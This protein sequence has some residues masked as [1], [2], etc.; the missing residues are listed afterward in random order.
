MHKYLFEL[1]HQPHI[2]IA[3]IQAVFSHKKIKHKIISAQGGSASGGKNTFFV[4]ENTKELNFEDLINTLGGTIKIAEKIKEDN[5]TDFL[6]KTPEEFKIQFSLSGPNSKKI[7]MAIKKQLK[8][9]GRSV[10]YIEPKNTATIL[11]NKLIKK[12]GDLTIFEDEIYLTKAIQPFEEFGARDY[13]RPGTDSFSG[14]LPPKLARIMINLGLD[15]VQTSHGAPLSDV[16]LLDPFCGSGTVLTEALDL[17]FKNIIGSDISEKAI[18]DTDENIKW[19]EKTYNTKP[20]TL[21]LTTSDATKL[22]KELDEDS[23]DLIV[24]EPYMGKPLR[25]NERKDTLKKQTGELAELY[26][27]SFREFYQ[28]LKEGGTVIFIIPKFKD[29]NDWVEIDCI[30]DIKCEGFELIPLSEE[31]DSLTYHRS[32]QHV[33][34]VIWKFRKV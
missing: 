5:I 25:G 21:K 17:G 33:A 2:S 14:M 12:Q 4:V 11:H 7:A 32:K 6:S 34:R 26:T 27:Q 8:S 1:G 23:V 22:S 30:D 10:R 15:S 29:E 20:N 9:M 16:V 28:I 19:I 18:T 31:S 24:S 13:K 3:E